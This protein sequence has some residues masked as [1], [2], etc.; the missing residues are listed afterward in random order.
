MEIEEPINTWKIR[1]VRTYIDVLTGSTT[2]IYELKSGT[3]K[4]FVKHNSLHD[5]ALDIVRMKEIYKM[6]YVD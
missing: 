1:D 2:G 4:G 5:T 3:P 6:L